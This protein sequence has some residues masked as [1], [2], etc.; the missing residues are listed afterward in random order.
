[1]EPAWVF[2]RW[3]GSQ[4]IDPTV[5]WILFRVGPTIRRGHRFVSYRTTV[6]VCIPRLLAVVV[7]LKNYTAPPLLCTSDKKVNT[8]VLVDNMISKSEW[9]VHSIA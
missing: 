2:D 4:V 5:A 6:F 3:C 9:Q 7:S 8:A 1:M